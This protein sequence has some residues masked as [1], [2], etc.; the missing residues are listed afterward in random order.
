MEKRELHHSAE[1]ENAGIKHLKS[2][3]IPLRVY[4]GSVI[5]LSE[6]KSEYKSLAFSV[7]DIIT[8]I[9]SARD[10]RTDYQIASHVKYPDE[11]YRDTVEINS[12][13]I[14]FEQIVAKMD[15]RISGT[16]ARISVQSDKISLIAE[17]TGEI[18]DS[19]ASVTLDVGGLES[20]IALKADRI[21]VEGKVSF[22]DLYTPGN[23]MINGG[24][25]TT[26]KINTNIIDLANT[27][28]LV[29]SGSKS[30][31]LSG[32]SS[33]DFNPKYGMLRLSSA[34]NVDIQAWKFTNFDVTSPEGIKVL[35]A[36]T[37]AGTACFG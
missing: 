31:V 33:I 15:K 18:E 7:G 13:A 14:K 24:N 28:N 25:I 17:K 5:N 16:N 9:D 1:A 11:P 20:E 22:T 29:G 12:P 23:T 10:V 3:A 36:I 8:L 27:I 21:E 34:G 4:D 35:D 30:I 19:L 2:L 6:L 26:G 32:S 37:P